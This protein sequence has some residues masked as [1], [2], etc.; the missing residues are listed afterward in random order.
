M[1]IIKWTNKFSG[2]FG[3]VADLEDNHFINTWEIKDAKK[4][5]TIKEADKTIDLL[6]EI[7]E[8][9]NNF[10]ELTDAPKATAT[11]AASKTT[12]KKTATAKKT[13]ATKKTATAKT[14]AK[15]TKTATEK[16]TK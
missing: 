11:K 5:R 9:Q 7:G 6:N 2:E 16:T 12:A 14:T 13:T 3:Y 1:K 4:F 8:G 10:F 15:T